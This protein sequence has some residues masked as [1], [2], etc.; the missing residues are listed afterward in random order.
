MNVSISGFKPCAPFEFGVLWCQTQIKMKGVGRR[1]KSAL[2]W[3]ERLITLQGLIRVIS[4]FFLFVFLVYSLNYQTYV[5]SVCVYILYTYFSDA[6]A[7]GEDWC[8]ITLCCIAAPWSAVSGW[9]RNKQNVCCK[10]VLGYF[11][12]FYATLFFLPGLCT[13]NDCVRLRADGAFCLQMSGTA[14]VQNI[15]SVQCVFYFSL[16]EASKNDKQGVHSRF[17]TVCSASWIYWGLR[18]FRN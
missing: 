3:W 5:S 11:K 10:L 1:K 18:Q 7:C 8:S 13:S 15:Y 14:E 12:L 4:S 2:Y 16:W 6:V 17:T 9:L